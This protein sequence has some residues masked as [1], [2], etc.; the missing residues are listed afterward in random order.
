MQVKVWDLFVR[1][2]HWL[3]V[4]IVL[5]AWLS[6]EFG[7]TEYKWHSLNG[8]AI[9]VLVLTRILWGFF[10]STTAR[11]SHFV[12]SPKIFFRYILASRSGKS[13]ESL[14]HNPAGGWMI[15]VLLMVL[16]AQATTGMFT[17]DDISFE[18]PFAY[19]V[20][21]NMSE[22][23]TSL[24]LLLFNALLGLI[25]LHVLAVLYHQLIKKES[26]IRAMFTGNKHTKRRNKNESNTFVF[27]SVFFALGILSTIGF[28]LWWLLQ[29]Y[30]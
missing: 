30:A 8:Y 2:S 6:S 14:G 26:I 18:G 3:I 5:S 21:T 12:K 7:D 19:Y 15:A 9:F 28:V 13:S 27:R 1:F 4:L 17:S 22:R 20:S 10:G 29:E 23:L 11:F 24:H 25:V 16:L